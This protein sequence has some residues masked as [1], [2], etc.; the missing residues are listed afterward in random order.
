M[1]PANPDCDRQPLPTYGC[2]TVT[3]LPDW[4]WPA[5]TFVALQ[6][7]YEGCLLREAI[8]GFQPMQPVDMVATSVDTTAL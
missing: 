7:G 3:R 6:R 1:A 5:L 8:I 4:Q 2:I